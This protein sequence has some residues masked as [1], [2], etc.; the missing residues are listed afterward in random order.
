MSNI[1][2][3]RDSPQKQNYRGVKKEASKLLHSSYLEQKKDHQRIWKLCHTLA[4][5]TK[6]TKTWGT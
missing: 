2:G 4:W 6:N 3:Q 5:R 1:E